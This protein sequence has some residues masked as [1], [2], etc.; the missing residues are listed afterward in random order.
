MMPRQKTDQP[1][2]LETFT[3]EDGTVVEIRD[4]TCQI[5]G[6]GLHKR[7]KFEE[8]RDNIMERVVKDYFVLDKSDFYLKRFVFK[9][10]IGNDY[11]QNASSFAIQC[12]LWGHGSEEGVDDSALRKTMYPEVLHNITAL[13]NALEEK[14]KD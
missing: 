8:K 1:P 3:L 11:L 5:R 7:D 2:P 12:E 4:E 9:P 13:K 10:P 6:R 14:Q